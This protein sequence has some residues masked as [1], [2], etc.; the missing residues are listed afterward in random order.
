MSI[1]CSECER[2]LRGGHDPA[3]SRYSPCPLCN[4]TGK[5]IIVWPLG[6][7]PREVDCVDCQEY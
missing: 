5:R 2:D 4:G 1:E 6:T 3:C 7:L